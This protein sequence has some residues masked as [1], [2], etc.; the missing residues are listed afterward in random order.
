MHQYLLYHSSDALPIPL[1]ILGDNKALCQE[2]FHILAS[3]DASSDDGPS[4]LPPSFPSSDIT[5]ERVPSGPSEDDTELQHSSSLKG[6]AASDKY[7]KRKVV[8]MHKFEKLTLLHSSETE[9]LPQ[10]PKHQFILHVPKQDLDQQMAHVYFKSNGLYLVVIR[11]DDLVEN[12]LSQYSKLFY[13]VHLIHTYVSPETERMIIVGMYNRSNIK[14]DDVLKSVNLVNKVLQQYRQAMRLPLEEKG[15]LFVFNRENRVP[16]CQYLCSCIAYCL[17]IFQQSAYSYAK[18]FYMSIFEPFQSFQ[19]IAS[20]IGL[21]HDRKVM[22]TKYE[23]CQRYCELFQKKVPQHYYETLTAYSPVCI[24]KG[25][26]GGCV[27]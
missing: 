10:M 19:Q 27:I 25:C 9:E 4:H 11:L 21:N 3:T 12:P 17:K 13:W 23:M 15:F 22:E 14:E 16:D 7:M 20:R 5:R 8:P 26:E 6:I 18:S 24:S 2:L 1:F